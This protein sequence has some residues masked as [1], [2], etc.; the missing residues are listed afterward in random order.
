V[1][2]GCSALDKSVQMVYTAVDLEGV[3]GLAADGSLFAFPKEVLV[4]T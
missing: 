2:K 3:T 1:F 4:D